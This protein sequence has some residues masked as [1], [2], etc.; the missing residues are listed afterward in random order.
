MPINLPNIDLSSLVD[1]TP[2][3]G[4]NV[5]GSFGKGLSSGIEM[6]LKQKLEEKKREHEAQIKAEQEQRKLQEAYQL[7]QQI[8]GGGQGEEQYPSYQEQLP[9]NIERLTWRGV[10]YR[11]PEDQPTPYQTESERPPQM[12]RKITP[13]QVG[14]TKL[15][16]KEAGDALELDYKQQ[17]KK[18]AE[19]RQDRREERKEAFK[20]NATYRDLLTKEGET[21]IPKQADIDRMRNAVDEGGLGLFSKDWF[22]EKFK[23]DWLRTLDGASF[24]S[25]AKNFLLENIQRAGSRPNQWIEQ[26][27]QDALAKIGQSREANLIIIEAQQADLNVQKEKQRLYAE[28]SRQDKEKYG[29][30]REGLQQRVNERLTAIAADKLLLP[31][32]RGIST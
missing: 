15:F 18:L 30:V 32:L 9:E 26:Q 23:A 10:P 12:R 22:A 21:I 28:L 24:R 7:Y 19:D 17:Q 4:A 29:Y 8:L 11:M 27:I 31:F 1:R 25:A 20:S 2:S 14:A 3:A 5:W 16:N 6:L 13:L